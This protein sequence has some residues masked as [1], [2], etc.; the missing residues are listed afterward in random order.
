MEEHPSLVRP[1]RKTGPNE[2]Q[3]DVLKLFRRLEERQTLGGE[4][5]MLAI[6]RALLLN[7]RLLILDEPSEGL[8]PVVIEQIATASRCSASA[9]SG[10]KVP[11]VS[12]T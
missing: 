10:G 8:A 7:P 6:A 2:A 5:Q 4:H 11:P 12:W 3:E 1:S 9:R